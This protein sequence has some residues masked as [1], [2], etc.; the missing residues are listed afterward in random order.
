MLGTIVNVATVIAGTSVGLL[1]K[2]RLPKKLVQTI[3]Q[4]I[5]LVTLVIGVVMALKFNSLLIVFFSMVLGAIIGEAIDIEVFAERGGV[6]LKQKIKVGGDKF[7]EGILTAFLMFCMG[8]MTILGAFDEGMKND[9]TLLITKSVM[10]GFSSMVLASALG[11][12]V[13]FSVIPLLIYQGGLT[14]LAGFLGNFFTPPMIAE[15]TATGGILLIGL[16]FNIL[17]IK[18]IKVFNLLPAL[19]FAVLFAWLSPYLNPVF[20]YLNELF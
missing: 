18:K 8:S 17:E 9:S 16:G 6:L 15:L 1:L 2:S 7:S 19:V 20:Q 12:G 5:G 13:G 10:D 3:F 4:A 11:I 14:L